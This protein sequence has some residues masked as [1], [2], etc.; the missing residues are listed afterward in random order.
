MNK[1]CIIKSGEL[2][3]AIL[4]YSNILKD[5]VPILWNYKGSYYWIP[6]EIVKNEINNNCLLKEIDCKIDNRIITLTLQQAY[7]LR[8]D[9]G[10]ILEGLGDE[11]F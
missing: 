7:P 4:N 5:P 2:E 11:K 10:R 8:Q 3:L 9:V 1:I 6:V